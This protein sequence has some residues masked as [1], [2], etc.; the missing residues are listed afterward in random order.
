MIGNKYSDS[1]DVRELAV[2]PLS[3]GK[4]SRWRA[5]PVPRP[6][7]GAGLTR[8]RT[9]TEATVWEAWMR[10]HGGAEQER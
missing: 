10:A 7:R 1:K 4:H 5:Q 3:R 9:G 8:V 6:T 2:W